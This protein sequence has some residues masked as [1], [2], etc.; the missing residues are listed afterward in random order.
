MPPSHPPQDPQEP[1]PAFHLPPGWQITLTYLFI[2]LAFLWIWQEGFRRVAVRPIPYS[3][4]KQ[5]LARGE[6]TDAAVRQDEIMGKVVPK[7][8]LSAPAAEREPFTFTTTRIEDAGLVNELQKAGTRYVGVRPSFL[9]S[10]L[11]MW[12]LPIAAFVFLGRFLGRRLGAGAESVLGFGRN[13]AGILVDKKTG[14]SFSDVAGCEEAKTELAEVVDFLKAPS[15]YEALGAKIPKGVL[16][17]GPPG[18]GKTLLA[19]AVAGEA[20]VPFFSISGSEFM[21]MFVGVGAARVRDLFKQAKAQAP[22]IIFI[23]EIDSVGRNRAVH[24]GNIN[25]EREQTLNQLL[26]EMDGFQAN[27]GVILL[28]ATNRPDVLDRALLRPGRFDRQVVVD[29]PDLKGREDI[30]A[31]Y[32]RNKPME[33]D[34]N[35]RRIADITAGFSGADLANCVNEAA[36]LAA[37]RGADKLAQGDL[38]ESVE[39]V[40][41][42][43]ERKSRRL[44]GAE[45]R[46]VAFHESGHALVAAFSGNADP[47]RKV[48]LVPRGRAA[49]GYTL[50]VPEKEKFLLSR[51][52]LVDQIKSLMG[53][54]AAEDLVFGEAS[55]GAENDLER[56]TVLARQMVGMHGMGK[57]SGLAHWA[58]RQ[59]GFLGNPFNGDG[60]RQE[61][62]EE[63]A[64]EIDHEVKSLLQDSYQEASGILNQHRRVLDRVAEELLRKETLDGQAF[65]DILQQA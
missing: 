58:Q 46:R 5:R 47:V 30:L 37:R 4:F 51:S 10:F 26:A 12:A 43:P 50:Q 55:T 45:K 49:L 57:A 8:P 48:S 44:D 33:K 13:R 53:G 59:D 21:E 38:E 23:D 60:W 56:A 14:V 35:L 27:L 54:R 63:T 17:V 24:L 1:K 25:D 11:L 42:G 16:L 41:A 52:Q 34:V 28:A 18:S 39:K 29:L 2:V 40:M 9:S 36:L 20:G 3:E 22:C 31:I 19:R 7:V 62:S 61:C 65:R 64:T 6:V 15:R 32:A